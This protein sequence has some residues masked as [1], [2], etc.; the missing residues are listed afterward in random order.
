MEDF[1]INE[2]MLFVVG[3]LGSVGGLCLII[4]KS[5]CKT[6]KFC[7]M[8]CERDIAAIIE[9]EKLQLGKLPTPRP[10]PRQDD[11]LPTLDTEINEVEK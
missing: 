1:N 4:Q 9:E 3:C 2:L 5:K 11:D 7:G 6:I 8:G 10:L